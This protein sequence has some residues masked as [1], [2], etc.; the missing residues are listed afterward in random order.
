MD[1]KV[2][3]GKQKEII[4][5]LNNVSFGYTQQYFFVLISNNISF[6][7]YDGDILRIIDPNYAGKT[8]LFKYILIIQ[9]GYSEHILIFNQDI[10]KNK[11][12]IQI[13]GYVQ[14][15]N[16]LSNYFL[17]LLKRLYHLVSKEP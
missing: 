10:W 16:P 9:N 7:E 17:W 3:R 15:K 14:Q 2:I 8:M 6:N 13:L 1:S 4:F 11:N 12:V 5:S